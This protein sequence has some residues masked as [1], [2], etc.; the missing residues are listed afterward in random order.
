MTS[1]RGAL[2][3][4]GRHGA[5]PAPARHGSAGPAGL[6]A[7]GRAYGTARG[8]APPGTGAAL[9]RWDTHVALPPRRTSPGPRGE[10]RALPQRGAPPVAFPVGAAG[11]GP[12]GEQRGQHRH[13]ESGPQSGERL[14]PRFPC[15]PCSSALCQA[16]EDKGS[17]K[18]G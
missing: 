12:G 15:P 1:E 2:C 13:G 4:H 18:L 14:S 7:P 9:P 10:W 6:G 8:S 16:R 3:S 11:A 5:A 17:P